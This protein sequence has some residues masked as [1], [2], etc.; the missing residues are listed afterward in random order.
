MVAGLDPAFVGG[1]GTVKAAPFPTPILIKPWSPP[2]LPALLL[3][4]LASLA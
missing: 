4:W 3:Q 1:W 2:A